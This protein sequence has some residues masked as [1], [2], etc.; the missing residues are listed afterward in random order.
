MHHKRCK[1]TSKKQEL[2]EEDLISIEKEIE[3]EMSSEEVKRSDKNNNLNEKKC[4]N[5]MLTS[6]IAINDN[7]DQH[8]EDEINVQ[9]WTLFKFIE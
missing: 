4:L 3:E 7:E 6:P 9:E 1:E 2:A 5:K 8:Q